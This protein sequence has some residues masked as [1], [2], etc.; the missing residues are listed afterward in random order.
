MSRWP[1]RE[2]DRAQAAQATKGHI[3]I[4]TDALGSYSGR[5]IAGA[6]AGENIVPWTVAIS[7]KLNISAVAGLVVPYPSYAEV[8]TRRHYIFL[9]GFDEYQGTSHHSMAASLE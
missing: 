9:A 4:I 5:D 1:Y 3:K 7:Q 2:N 8:E 6:Q